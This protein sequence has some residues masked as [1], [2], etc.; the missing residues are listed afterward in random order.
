MGDRTA[1]N[2]LVLIYLEDEP[3]S[4]A[5]IEDIREDWKKGWYHVTML[6][7]QIPLQVITWILRDRYIDGEEFT[8][9]GKRIRLEKVVAPVT[10]EPTPSPEPPDKMKNENAVNEASK[11][12]G[13]GK[14]ISFGQRKK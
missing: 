2:D 1:I 11:T 8:M 14:V 12:T 9:D 6:F 4:F 7:L 10:T 13:G 5:R 3:L